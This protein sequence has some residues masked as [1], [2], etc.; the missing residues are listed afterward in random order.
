MEDC[1][2]VSLLCEIGVEKVD[3][4]WYVSENVAN[5]LS[6]ATKNASVATASQF[7][8]FGRDKI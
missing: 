3:S 8:L 1:L 4:D 7:P 6:D 5:D 2:I